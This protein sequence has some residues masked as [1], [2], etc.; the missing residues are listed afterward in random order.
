MSPE[1]IIDFLMNIDTLDTVTVLA[2]IIKTAPDDIQYVVSE[3]ESE[4]FT[5]PIEPL[6]VFEDKDNKKKLVIFKNST[7]TQ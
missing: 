4:E 1:F 6:I 7:Y 5:P 2:A 3:M